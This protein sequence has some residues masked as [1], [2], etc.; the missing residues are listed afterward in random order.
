MAHRHKGPAGHSLPLATTAD[1][2]DGSSLVLYSD[3][4]TEAF[5]KDG[6]EFGED[7]L[8]NLGHRADGSGDSFLAHMRGQL[9][10]FTEG[11]EQSDDITIMTI[12]HH[13]F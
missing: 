1:I 10:E 12:N 9:S 13:G 8:L 3:G 11:A 7:R 4:V 6:S 2:P 5:N